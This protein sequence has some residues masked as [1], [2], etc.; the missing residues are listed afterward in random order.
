MEA[1]QPTQQIDSSDQ[2]TILK[3]FDRIQINC[4]H[5]IHASA[6]IGPKGEID[7]SPSH[8]IQP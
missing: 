5:N 7:R 1:L 3:R 8:L 4:Q 6:E 2:S